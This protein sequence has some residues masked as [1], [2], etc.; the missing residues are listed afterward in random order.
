[1]TLED[2]Q[3]LK[4]GDV[5]YYVTGNNWDLNAVVCGFS[6]R[7][8]KGA[9][10]KAPA[11]SAKSVCIGSGR[12]SPGDVL[13][14]ADGEAAMAAFEA[15][16]REQEAMDQRWLAVRTRLQSATGEAFG[17]SFG[18]RERSHISLVCRDVDKAERIAAAV[19]VGVT[20][21][22]MQGDITALAGPDAPAVHLHLSVEQAE[23]V[24][25][26]LRG[27]PAEDR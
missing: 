22:R 21:L 23:R 4:A 8:V 13:T 1:M 18:V 10:S 27:A 26:V 6:K 9:V 3:A 24:L 25:A 12:Y 11:K 19:E 7:L 5:V 16:K 14:I 15:K 17:D 20:A 2:M